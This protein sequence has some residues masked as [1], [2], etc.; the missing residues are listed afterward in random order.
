MSGDWKELLFY[1]FV[2]Q[3][4]R[5]VHIDV[6]TEL[7]LKVRK[8]HNTIERLCFNVNCVH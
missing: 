7:V 2:V 5:Y 1:S 8:L 6:A 4:L 3:V